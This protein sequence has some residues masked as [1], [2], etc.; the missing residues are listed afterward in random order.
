MFSGS[1][2]PAPAPVRR[3]SVRAGRSTRLLLPAR[4]TGWGLCS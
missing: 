2:K 3:R 1:P 4:H